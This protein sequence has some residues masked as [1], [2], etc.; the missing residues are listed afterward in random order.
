MTGSEGRSGHLWLDRRHF[1]KLSGL[2]AVAT[3][4][5]SLPFLHLREEAIAADLAGASVARNPAK[6]GSWQDLYRQRWSWDR[7]AKGTHGW[8]NC[9]SACNFDLYVKDGIVVREEQTANYT[10]SEPGVPDFNP[11]GCQKGA[12]YTEVMYGPS[13]LTV[14]LKRVGPR[15]GG[16]WQQISWDTALREIAEKLVT[17][18]EKDGT[19]SIIHDLGPHFDQGP[20]TAGRV[21]FFGLAGATL[22]DDWAE[23]G[24]LNHGATLTFGFPH[25]G[26]SSDEWFLSDYLVV[27]MMNPAVTQIPDAHFLFEAKYDGAELVVIDPQ[28][29]A[30]AVHADQ[31]IPIKPGTD[32]ALALATARHIWDTGRIDL[33][34]VREQTDLPILVRL[35]T[36]RFLTEA[37]LREGGGHELVYV[38]DPASGHA[39]GRA[40]RS[41]QRR[42]AEARRRSFRAAD[43]R[44]LRG[45]AA[46]RHAKPPSSPWVP[47]CASTSSPGRWRRRPR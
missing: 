7:V 9:R 22:S 11:R 6:L 16:Q 37:D 32:A 8:L 15:G 38:W 33:A 47:S 24:D 27:W 35:D 29:S 39:R 28:Y 14:P 19:D 17:I 23:I 4:A 30:T 3:A 26:G 40:G 12:C 25:V 10:A 42:R 45:E 36:G 43:R 13:R 46:R 18:A 41:R 44:S 2:A 34:Y 5:G 31:W 1:L 20:T 21:R